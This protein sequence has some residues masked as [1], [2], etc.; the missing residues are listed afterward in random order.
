M[1]ARGIIVRTT[2]GNAFRAANTSPVKTD[3]IIGGVA[4]NPFFA[5]YDEMRVNE[6]RLV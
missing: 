3:E 4:G 2:S 1:G 6:T 5:E